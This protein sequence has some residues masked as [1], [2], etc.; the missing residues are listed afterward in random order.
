MKMVLIKS[1]LGAAGVA[2]TALAL[3][4]APAVANDGYHLPIAKHEHRFSRY[5]YDRHGEVVHRHSGYGAHVHVAPR[6]E[7]SARRG[8]D[9]GRYGNDHHGHDH[10]RHS[11]HRHDHHSDH[12][13]K[14]AK[15][16]KKAKKA[17]LFL[18]AFGA[19]AAGKH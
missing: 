6:H 16:L 11:G 13:S 4:V 17:K 14:D 5:D 9:H 18:K 12:G 3:N 15:K 1:L 10:G 8:R 19:L 2:A 7:R